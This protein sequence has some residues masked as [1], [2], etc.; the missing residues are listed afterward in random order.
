VDFGGETHSEPGEGA[1]EWC[2]LCV[3]GERRLLAVKRI[4][5]MVGPGPKFRNTRITRN[6]RCY[7]GGTPRCNFG[8][9]TFKVEVP[10]EGRSGDVPLG[11]MSGTPN[12]GDPGAEQR[13]SRHIRLEDGNGEWGPARTTDGRGSIAIGYFVVQ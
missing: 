3:D 12:F 2:Q 7:E 11:N 8:S 9:G 10:T 13:S 1:G 5:N 6:V 4:V